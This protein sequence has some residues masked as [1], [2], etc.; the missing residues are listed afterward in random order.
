M[1]VAKKWMD[2][3]SC[4]NGDMGV[5]WRMVDVCKVKLARW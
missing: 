5:V 2:G 3:N 1:V 4:E